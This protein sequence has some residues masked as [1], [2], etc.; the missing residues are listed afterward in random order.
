[1]PSTRSAAT[2]PR[3][4]EEHVPA[5]LLAA[6]PTLRQ[7]ARMIGVHASSLSRRDLPVE[8]AGREAR[9]SP[10]LVL[11]LAAHYRRRDEYE[12][13]G[14]L[15]DYA[16]ARAPDR[17]GEVEAEIEHYFQ[18]TGER[19]APLDRESFLEEA[20]RHLSPALYAQVERAYRA[21]QR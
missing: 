20:R 11:E 14:A 8:H 6:Y 21:N 2:A 4:R 18:E 7:A 5:G 3:K 15:L 12:V 10:R 9:L 13:G 1:M 16:L 17:V 19:D